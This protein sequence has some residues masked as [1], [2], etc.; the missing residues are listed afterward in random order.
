MT[1]ES[2]VGEGGMAVEVGGALVEV[3]ASG[4][5]VTVGA[6]KV[7]LGSPPPT[8]HADTVTTR[9]SA[10]ANRRASE[11]LASMR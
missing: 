9:T 7:A 1:S 5:A 6:G 8:E 10:K 2:G 11:C 3:G 4:E